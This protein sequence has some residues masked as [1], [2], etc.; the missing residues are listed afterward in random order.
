MLDNK[1]CLE[2]N[3]VLDTCTD[4]FVNFEREIAIIILVIVVS[5]YSWSG[6]RLCRLVKWLLVTILHESISVSV[7]PHQAVNI[8]R[9]FKGLKCLNHEGQAVHSSMTA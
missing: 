2:N 7:T 3:A 6:M 9:C 4:S 5:F 8:Y 1:F